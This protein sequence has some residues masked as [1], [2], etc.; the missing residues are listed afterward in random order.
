MMP[1]FAIKSCQAHRSYHQA[2]RDTWGK[3]FDIL[4]FM[5]AKHLAPKYE[6]K[7][8]VSLDC[9]DSYMGLPHKTKA[10]CEYLVQSPLL[11][12]HTHVY[13]CDNDTFVR[14]ESFYR[15]DYDYD[16][17]GKICHCPIG[18]TAPY[19]DHMGHY[20]AC[21]PWASGGIGYFVSSRRVKL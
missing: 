9:D 4:F 14:P 6:R 21:H 5:G 15:L 3:F 16:Y 12:N 1:L 11:L 19:T 18:E 13:F 8:E 2:I 7:D 17:A 10:I 20:P